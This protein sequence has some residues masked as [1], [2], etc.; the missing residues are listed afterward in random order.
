[1]HIG[2]KIAKAARELNSKPIA[3]LMSQGVPKSAAI[4]LCIKTLIDMGMPV[5]KA[6]DT[7]LGAGTFRAISDDVWETLNADKG[8]AAARGL[9]L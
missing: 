2:N 5:D 9:D 3:Y 1:M 8:C 7:V 6:I 4:S